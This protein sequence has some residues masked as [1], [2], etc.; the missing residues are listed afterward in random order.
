[1][2]TLH[3]EFYSK[4]GSDNAENINVASLSS[5]QVIHIPSLHLQPK[6]LV[7][8]KELIDKYQMKL[9]ENTKG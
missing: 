7:L 6:I 8:L 5:L 1:M 4:H 3:F 2:S 9:K